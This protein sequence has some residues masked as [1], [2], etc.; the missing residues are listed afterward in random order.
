MQDEDTTRAALLTPRI[1]A[2]APG[3]P[4][5]LPTLGQT[6][7]VRG[8]SRREVLA[9]RHLRDKG[10][11]DTEEKWEAHMLSRTMVYPK[12]T[13]EQVLEWQGASPAGEM[14]PVTDKVS[15]LSALNDDA[16][17]SDVPVAGSESGD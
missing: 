4:V 16:D 12:M 9:M 15:E 14:N 5:P 2:A 3:E 11:L 13:F 10:I 7:R 1:D 17:K 8:L 6:V